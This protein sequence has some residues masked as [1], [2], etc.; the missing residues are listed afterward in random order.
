MASDSTQDPARAPG[1]VPAQG[2]GR[3]R[4]ALARLAETRLNARLGLVADATVAI[5]LLGAGW[6]AADAA[7]TASF[8]IAAGLL[9]FSF[10]EYSFHRWLFHGGVAAFE[11][12]HR[13]HHDNPRGDNALPFFLTPLGMGALA[14]A[15]HL[16]APHAV[17]LL[18]AGA[19]AAGYAAY[20]I[21][22]TA[23]H[24]LRLR[25]PFSARW[26]ARHHVHHYHPQR[27]FGVT[28][29]LWDIVLRTRYVRS[30]AL[31]LAG[32]E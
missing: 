19:L 31:H 22:H 13:L 5:A 25:G 32:H 4:R 30:R 7:R 23:I 16:V 14:A 1:A 27:N 29:P 15:L 20:G 10:V 3:P 2:A 21:A 11:A 28:T 17:A 6:R 26:A 24:R 18:F 12:G 9:V 8:A